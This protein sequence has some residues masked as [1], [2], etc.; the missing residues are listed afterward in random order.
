MRSNIKEIKKTDSREETI[1]INT[2]EDLIR[3]ELDTLEGVINETTDNKKAAL[4]FTG[5]RTV[6][7]TLK[8]GLEARKL[9]MG[10]VAGVDVGKGVK[11]IEDE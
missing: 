6:T 1:R 9:G 4:L 5:A 3:L 11:T 2:L 10:H 8:L 7:A